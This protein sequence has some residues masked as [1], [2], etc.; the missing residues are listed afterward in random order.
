MGFYS[1]ERVRTSTTRDFA[2][3]LRSKATRSRCFR[4]SRTRNPCNSSMRSGIRRAGGLRE[5]VRVTAWRP[6]IG[7]LL[8]VYV[9]DRYEGVEARTYLE[10]SDAEIEEYLARNVE[11]VRDHLRAQPPR[12]RAR[13]PP[14][15][16]ARRAGA[17]AR[18]RRALRGEGPR[19]RAGVRRQARSR[20]LPALRARGARPGAR[21]C[22]SA[23]AT[24][25]RACGRR[26]ATTSCRARTRLGPPGVDVE[27]FRPL[28]DAAARGGGARRAA[29]ARAAAAPVESAFSRDARAAAAALRSLRPGDRHVVFVGKLIVSKGVDLLVGGM[30]AGARAGARGAAGDRGLRR[31]PRGAGA[32]AAPRWRPGTS[33]RCAHWPQEGRAA[34]GGPRAPL[35]HLLAFL[36]TVDDGLPRGRARAARP[37]RADRAP[38]ARRAGAAAGDGRGAG[39]P[40]HVPRGVRHGRRRGGRLR[41]AAGLVGPLRAGRGDAHARRG[42]ARAGAAVAV[43]R[44]G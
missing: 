9:A 12:H 4:R 6:D 15:D 39:G 44:G 34:E 27:E 38:R 40:Q 37:R 18:R 8:P 11:A 7:G 19:Q 23:R 21:R 17:G 41:G 43:V 32:A 3:L 2:Q 22:S 1:R 14:R 29:R 31:L 42:G 20:A 35:R 26:W 24:P 33:R 30:A 5:P 25:P 16:G 36:D 10:I 13:Q 28:P